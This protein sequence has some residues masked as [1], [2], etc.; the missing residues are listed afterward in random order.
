M[1]LT[2]LWWWIDRWRK[3]T[4]FMDMTLEQQGAYRNLLDEACLRGGPLPNDPRVL[5]KACGDARRWHRVGKIVMA[6]FQ[7]TAD[8]WRNETL[9][10]VLLEST[11]RATKQKRYREGKNAPT[12]LAIIARDGEVC[13]VCAQPLTIS[14]AEIDHVIP[15]T[16]GGH[17]TSV[18][19]LQLA[20]PGCNHKKGDRSSQRHQ[21]LVPIGVT[22]DVTL[23]ADSSN[24]RSNY[25]RPPDP[26]PDPDLI[27]GSGTGKRGVNAR[28]RRPIFQGQRFVVFDWMLE[29][30]SRTLGSQTDDFDLHSWFF[31]IDGALAAAG[32]VLPKA[33]QWPWL[34]QQ[35]VA[36]VKRRGLPM[37]GTMLPKALCQHQP[38]CAD[39]WAHD[40]LARA[41]ASGD[42]ELVGKV[43]ALNAKQATA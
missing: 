20:H 36:E 31:E 18:E 41:E 22:L 30:M 5:A 2:G 33:E 15:L 43:K 7:L 40:R 1:R 12:V 13:G 11:R 3:S 34:Q 6:R 14:D 38:R 24:S 23:K 39:A 32:T 42:L 29:D 4:A 10:E 16:R 8:G 19:N 21:S 26:D 35:L 28:S 9:D 25:Q 37:A 17:P 27:T